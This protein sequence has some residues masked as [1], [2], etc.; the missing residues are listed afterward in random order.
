ME[1]LAIAKLAATCKIGTGADSIFDEIREIST[2]LAN[3]SEDHNDMKIFISE[4][5]QRIMNTSNSL[6]TL[7]SD[8]LLQLHQCNQHIEETDRRW[9]WRFELLMRKYKKYRI[10]NVIGWILIIGLAI[11]DIII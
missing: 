6:V 8:L 5:L 2:E 1:D 3:L 4:R 11:V 9:G 10:I 7:N